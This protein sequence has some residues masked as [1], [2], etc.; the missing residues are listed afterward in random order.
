[1]ASLK[2]IDETPSNS[3]KINFL[4][5]FSNSFEA[6]SHAQP[7]SS[8]K[9]PSAGMKKENK[10]ARPNFSKPFNTEDMH[11]IWSIEQK[12]KFEFFNNNFEFFKNRPIVPGRVIN[13]D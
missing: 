12:W 3:L 1:M 6:E 2:I 5:L 4:S 7:S 9:K 8:K 10:K 11:K 13:W